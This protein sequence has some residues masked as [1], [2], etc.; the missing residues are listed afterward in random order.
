MKLGWIVIVGMLV[1]G[2][3]HWPSAQ[4]E[5]VAPRRGG[6]AGTTFWS[7]PMDQG[8]AVWHDGDVHPR[9]WLG[10]RDAEYD[11]LADVVIVV[12]PIGRSARPVTPPTGVTSPRDQSI[13]CFD[14]GPC[15]G[16]VTVV[17][18]DRLMVT[19]YRKMPLAWKLRRG[20]RDVLAVDVP[21]G[22]EEL[23]I[24]LKDVPPGVYDLVEGATGD[25]VGWIYRTTPDAPV[26]GATSGNCRYVIDLAP[27]RYRVVAWHPFLTPVEQVVVVRAGVIR[28]VNV[29]FSKANLPGKKAK[30]GRR[31][32]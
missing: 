25:R 3:A 32:R 14:E 19:N 7:G 10:A 26:A 5:P 4:A 11:G 13:E 16:P 17:S 12:T 18:T 20:G 30:G 9:D 23:A 24:D 1:A 8:D 6:I 28:R 2:A 31:R 21:A 27:G 22:Q 29:V 15:S